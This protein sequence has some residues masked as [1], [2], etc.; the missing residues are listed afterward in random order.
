VA[1]P[2]AR[3]GRHD[4]PTESGAVNSSTTH[5]L[6]V[7]HGPLPPP[8]VLEAYERI[9]PGSTDRVLRQWER[10]TAH[11][12]EMETRPQTLPFWDSVLARVT[13]LLFAF[14]CLGVIAYA[15]SVGAQWAAAVLSGAMV[16]AGINAFIRR[17]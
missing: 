14:G 13:A 12:H 7:W 15:V 5:E 17:N 10:E 3:Q 4:E 11:R 9:L 6:S 8:A 2:P 16:I 1:E